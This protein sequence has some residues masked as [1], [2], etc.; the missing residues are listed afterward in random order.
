[1]SCPSTCAIERGYD[2]SGEF[3]DKCI[4]NDLD[5]NLSDNNLFQEPV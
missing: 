1:M 3:S 2:S 5:K 4:T